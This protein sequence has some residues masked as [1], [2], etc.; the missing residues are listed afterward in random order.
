MT[1]MSTRKNPGRGS[2]P[3]GQNP[4]PTH[5]PN[6]MLSG[7]RKNIFSIFKNFFFAINFVLELKTKFQYNISKHQYLYTIKRF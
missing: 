4:D 6:P 5:D 7:Q 3:L 1:Y 2:N